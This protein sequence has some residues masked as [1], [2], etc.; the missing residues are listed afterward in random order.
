ML[1]DQNKLASS[2]RDLTPRMRKAL[3][4]YAADPKRRK[5]EAYRHAY[6]VKNLSDW[7]VS[8]RARELFRHPRM[9]GAV[10]A[11]NNEAAVRIGLNAEWV[12]SKLKL[13]AEFNLNKFIVVDPTDNIAYYDFSRATDDDWYCI[14]EYTTNKVHKGVGKIPA[15]QVKIK[16]NC[17]LK[18]L[19]LAGKHVGVGA[20]APET[21]SMQESGEEMIKA[22]SALSDKLPV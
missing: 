8:E 11:L 12:L 17:K 5:A 4:F 16:A 13:L 6:S 2:T 10:E 18:A 19:E 1:T 22:L 9:V 3:E 21:R 7:A 14:S 20:F 15:T